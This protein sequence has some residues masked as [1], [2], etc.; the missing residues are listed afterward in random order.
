M[1]IVSPFS[2]NEDM[3]TLTHIGKGA[4][5]ARLLGKTIMPLR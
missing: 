3:A 2:I 4:T 5:S 1:S